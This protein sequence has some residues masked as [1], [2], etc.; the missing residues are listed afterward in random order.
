MNEILIKFGEIYMIPERYAAW[1]EGEAHSCAVGL[2]GNSFRNSMSERQLEGLRVV[3][4]ASKE[5]LL[6]FCVARE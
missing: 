2:L 4:Q 6:V 1:R 3:K 5:G